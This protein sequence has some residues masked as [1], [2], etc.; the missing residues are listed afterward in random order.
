MKEV[1]K[2]DIKSVIDIFICIIYSK[3]N[4]LFF[5]NGY[6]SSLPFLACWIFI[7]ASSLLADV[8]IKSEKI[9]RKNVRKIF[10]GIGLIFPVVTIFG[11]AFVT[12]NYPYIGVALIT[13]GFAFI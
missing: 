1:L 13:I 11:L 6:M 2:F 8:I 10:N 3:I 7:N 12:C 4:D 9:S 5:K